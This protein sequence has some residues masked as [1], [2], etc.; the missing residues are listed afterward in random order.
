[1]QHY[2]TRYPLAAIRPGLR[3]TASGTRHGLPDNLPVT[4]P[5]PCICGSPLC[6]YVPLPDGSW[7]PDV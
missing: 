1:M 3:W 6:G 5:V 4:L 7:T 2:G